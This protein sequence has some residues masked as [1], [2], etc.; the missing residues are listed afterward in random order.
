MTL[1]RNRGLDKIMSNTLTI[2]ERQFYVDGD[3]NYV[4]WPSSIVGYSR[5][6][7]TTKQVCFNKYISSPWTA[8]GWITRTL[9]KFGVHRTFPDPWK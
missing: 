1:Y 8:V 4:F 5:K 9:I 2:K 3:P 6:R 7:G